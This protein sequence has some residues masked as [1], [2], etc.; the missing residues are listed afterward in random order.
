V[1]REDD[2]T[3]AVIGGGPAGASAAIAL[4]R[5]GIDTLL[6]ERSGGRGNAIGETL[7]PAANPLLHRLGLHDVLLAS[8]ARPTHSNRSSWGSE[9][10]ERAF[11]HD[12]HGHGWH[13][14]RPSFNAALL[15]CAAAAGAR[16]WRQ[17]RAIS[18]KQCASNGCWSL[19]VATV[20]GRRTIT[21]DMLIDA[22]GRASL[23][24]RMEGLRRRAYD[25]QVAAVAILGSEPEAPPMR[26]AATLIEATEQ[27]WW[28]SALL[29]NGRLVVA[30]FSD[31][32]LLASQEAWRV[33]GW[34]QLLRVSGVTRQR[35]AAHGFA[36]PDRIQVLAAGSSL[37]PRPVG[38][39]WIAVGD[40]AAA[41]DPLSSHGIASALAG[42][43]RAAESIAAALGGD[44][45][46]FLRYTDHTLADYAHYLWLRHAYYADE[47]R[48][49]EATFWK[50]RHNGMAGDG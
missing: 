40:A 42:G 17:A 5:C 21:A 6:L 39:G 27:G 19:A 49:P 26:D 32:D 2:A 16:I 9:L 30:W 37:L 25:A 29:P 18:G 43:A 23:V 38:D 3:V 10:A 24:S 13:L 15:E 33:S 31:P 50:R 36:R 12:P 20:D 34:W 48:W 44:A 35:V 11:L 45:T 14:D 4:A 46:A 22:T 1:S 47:Q 41:F 8:N 7:A 28:Y